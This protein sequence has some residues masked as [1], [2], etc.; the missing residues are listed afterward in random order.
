LERRGN[1]PFE[2]LGQCIHTR[3]SGTRTARRR[4]ICQHKAETG[5]GLVAGSEYTNTRKRREDLGKLTSR[6][7][8]EI[9]CRKRFGVLVLFASSGMN[10]PDSAPNARSESHGS[11]VGGFTTA[12]PVCWAVQQVRKTASYFIQSATTRFIAS[13]FP[14]RNRV[15]RKE[16]FEGLELCAGK[17]ACTV[18]RGL[19]PSNGARLLDS[20]EW[21]RNRE[22]TMHLPA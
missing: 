22:A 13:I 10:K 6:N 18:L 5:L 17:L 7:A 3:K 19:G 16:A 1:R 4:C 2:A 14:S 21:H 15:S 11:R 8:K 20:Q 12:S 9:I